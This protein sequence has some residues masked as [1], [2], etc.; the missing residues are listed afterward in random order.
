[1][2]VYGYGDTRGSDQDGLGGKATNPPGD[3]LDEDLAS[4]PTSFDLVMLVRLDGT[5]ITPHSDAANHPFS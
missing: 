2:D 4:S 5:A 1:M 3:R